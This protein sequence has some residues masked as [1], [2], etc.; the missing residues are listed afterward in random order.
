[1][2][3]PIADPQAPNPAVITVSELNKR[4]RELVEGAFPLLWVA[5]EISNFTRATSGHCYFSLKDAGAQ[6]RCVFFRHKAALLDWKPEN[7]M[8]V[9]GRGL[10]SFYEARGEFQLGIENMRQS[11]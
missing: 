4:A 8:Q 9:E 2:N 10:P 11:G 7:G 5:G 1:M 3:N 6:V